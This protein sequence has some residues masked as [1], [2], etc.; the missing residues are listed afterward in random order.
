MDPVRKVKDAVENVVEN[1]AG[2]VA[3]AMTP[4]VPGSPGSGVS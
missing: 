1:A 2:K 4:D 3:E